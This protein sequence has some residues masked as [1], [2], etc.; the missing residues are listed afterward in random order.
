MIM[1]MLNS[2]CFSIIIPTYNRAAFLPKAIES[3]LAQIY[4]DWELIIVDDGSADNT[5][6]IVAKY[7]DERIKYIYQDNAERSAA[8]NN[9]IA[10]AVGDYVCFMDSDN[11][12]KPDRLEKLSAFIEKE[13][14][15]ACYYTGIEYFNEQTGCRN[16]KEG[17]SYPFPM[18]VDLLIRDIVA[19]PQLCCST[20]IL[21]KHQFNPELSIGEDMEL[22]FRI[23]AEYPLIYILNQVTMVETE[24]EGRSVSMHS[25]ASEKQL[26]TL[27][28]M[29][30]KGHPANKV[31]GNQKKWLRSAVLF[32]A[33]RDYL[34]DRDLVGIKYLL[35]SLIVSSFCVSSP[36]YTTT[37][38]FSSAGI[39][40][41]DASMRTL[42]VAVST[43]PYLVMSLMTSPIEHPRMKPSSTLR[44]ISAA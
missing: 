32:N 12:M 30:S 21:R 37:M 43:P 34:I 9:G 44:A 20:E 16:I 38:A 18:D 31:S 42:C 36:S 35:N 5:K 4:T 8:R 25:K 27:K 13:N 6:D 15:L 17:H 33:S 40:T 29:F 26:K 24:H 41:M 28:V 23:T 1:C 3:V 11:Y 39:G 22:L 14:K 10:H 19:T 7:N 2:I